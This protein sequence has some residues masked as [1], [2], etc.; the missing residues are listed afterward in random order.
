MTLSF[1][2]INKQRGSS[3][4]SGHLRKRSLKNGKHSWQIVIER[5]IDS[6]TGERDRIYKTIKGGTK[7]QAEKEMNKILYEI[8]NNVYVEANTKTF[9]AFLEEWLDTYI[10]P[11]KS[12]TTYAGYEKQVK[13]YIIP[14]LGNK[15]LQHL[16]TLDI[17]KFYNSLLEKSPLSGK[18]M[19]PKTV[20]NIHMNVRAALS[21]ALKLD[22]I[23]KNPAENVTLPKVKKYKAEIYDQE[24]VELLIKKVKDTDLEVPICLEV[25][26]GL[27]RGELL[28]L[29]WQDID[30]DNCKVK[31]RNNLVQVGNEIIIKEPKTE[32]S[33]REIELP[34]TIIQLL[35]KERKKYIEKK[36][37]LGKEFND[38]DLIIC[39]K[40]GDP[41]KPHS[42]TNKFRRF[43]ARNNLKTIRL[44]DLRHTNATLML[45]YGINPKVAQQ[46][47]GHSSISTTMDVYSHV[48]T[49]V[50]KEAAAKLDSGIF[51]NEKI[52]GM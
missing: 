16:K 50:E 3:M 27:R 36:M 45:K 22:L 34:T 38:N 46:R 37:R 49:E 26:L 21:Q 2:T 31:I 40:N 43:I 4:A 30:F 17:Q 6:E 10:K 52:S 25:A 11:N 44:H 41:F 20:Q 48:I 42:F 28:A 51:S 33:I 5:D 12:P 29:K 7:K 18:P 15:K 24:E 13:N 9:G 47:L 1:I 39:K 19:K 32:S 35:K 14:A 8:N 23:K